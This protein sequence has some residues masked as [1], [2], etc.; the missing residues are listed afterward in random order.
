MRIEEPR[1]VEDCRHM[2]AN[3]TQVKFLFFWGHQ[4]SRSGDI[5]QGCLSQW[6]AGDFTVDGATYFSA[7]HWMIRPQPARLRPDGGT[8]RAGDRVGDL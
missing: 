1:S 3:G 6:W 5:C 8:V 2:E 7:E 4:P